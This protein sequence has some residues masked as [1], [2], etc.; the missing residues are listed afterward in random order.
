L[1]GNFNS[2]FVLQGHANSVFGAEVN[3][4]QEGIVLEGVENF[5]EAVTFRH[6]CDE[7]VQTTTASSNFLINLNQF[8][9]H[10][11]SSRCFEGTCGF[12]KAIQVNGGSGAITR[13]TFANARVPVL[14]AAGN[15]SVIVAE[16]LMRGTDPD[17]TTCPSGFNCGH[18]H[19]PDSAC[20]G[21][22]FQS[23]SALVSDNEMHHCKFGVVVRGDGLVDARNNRIF[24]GYLSA[25]WL[26]PS[27]NGSGTQ[28]LRG[29]GNYIEGAGFQDDS[30]CQRGA[31]VARGASAIV[32]FGGG[33][34]TGAAVIGT[35]SS[36]GNIFCQS[37]AHSEDGVGNRDIMNGA[38]GSCAA[39][40]SSIG[41]RSN[42]FDDNPQYTGAV[43]VGSYTSGC[44]C[45]LE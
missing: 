12:D 17:Q 1:N 22:E 44:D 28:R 11:S 14:L 36:G 42:C 24:D 20:S 4:F 6:Y 38:S 23:G 16:N 15:P 40:V 45:S 32:D 10:T 43:T 7:A 13:N 3:F 31:I 30:N 41:A 5:V 33:N 37:G 21:V 39:G 2:A 26:E 9:G 18:R 34:A 25:F 29:Q 19:F 35:R 8:L 27:N